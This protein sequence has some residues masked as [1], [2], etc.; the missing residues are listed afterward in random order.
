MGIEPVT[1]VLY[2]KAPDPQLLVPVLFILIVLC[3][4]LPEIL[5]V[6]STRSRHLF[7]SSD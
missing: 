7:Y 1:S 3:Y 4:M 2:L 5:L 6:V